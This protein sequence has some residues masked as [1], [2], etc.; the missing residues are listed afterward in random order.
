M[1]IGFWLNEDFGPTEGGGAS[2]TNRFLSLVD[3]FNF[4]EGIELCYVSIYPNTHFEREVIN[5]SQIPSFIY[6]L[7]AFSK[8]ILGV[9]RIIDLK[10]L[11]LRGLKSVLKGTDVKIMYYIQQATTIDSSFPFISTNWDIGHR[12]TFPFPELC[13]NNNFSLTF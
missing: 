13:N 3:R 7:C 2:Y 11:R 9:L 10:I 8:T 1:K 4:S 6:K 12:S 5:V